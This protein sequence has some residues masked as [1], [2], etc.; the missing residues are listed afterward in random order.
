[1]SRFK[2]RICNKPKDKRCKVTISSW[3]DLCDEYRYMYELG[4][5]D[6][7]VIIM[8][9]TGLKDFAGND[10]YEGDILN[11]GKDNYECLLIVVWD[12]N[13][14]AFHLKVNWHKI[15]SRE[16][17]SKDWIKNM[18]YEV[19]GNIYEN[20]E[21]VDKPKEYTFTEMRKQK[22]NDADKRHIIKFS[23]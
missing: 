19:V 10:I 22:H 7:E 18:R 2:F 15:N 8:Q 5:K 11:T 17:F 20:P 13:D 21:L 16:Y 4:I 3:S 1:M 9:C 6:D 12:E 14:A 23:F